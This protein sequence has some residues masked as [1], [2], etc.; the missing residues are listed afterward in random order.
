MTTTIIFEVMSR[1]GAG[2]TAVDADG[3]ADDTDM[4]VRLQVVMA[5]MLALAT[6][7]MGL[8]AYVRLRVLRSWGKD[9]WATLISYA[10]TSCVVNGWTVWTDMLHQIFVLATG[11]LITMSMS[12]DE[13]F[14]PPLPPGPPPPLTHE[15][16]A[17]STAGE[18]ASP[19]SPFNTARSWSGWPI[20]P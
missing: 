19:R 3:D 20:L 9:D 10:S 1:R 15:H 17:P 2:T 11:I 12:M 5:I 7:V 14:R 16:Q 8:R 6:V 18:C 13:C 4:R